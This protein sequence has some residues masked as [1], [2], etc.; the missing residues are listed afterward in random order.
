[1]TISADDIKRVKALGCLQDKTQPEY[2]NVRVITKNGRVSTDAMRTVADAADRFGSGMATLT[3]RLTFEIQGVHYDN[4][5]PLRAYLKENGLETGG[6]GTK[7]RPVVSCKGTTCQYG[8]Y[9]TY[10]LSEKAHE[11]FYE[12]YRDVKLPHKF[13]IAFGGCPN[14][15][16]KPNLNDCGVVGQRLVQYDTTKCKG[17]KVCQIEKNCPVH[18]ASVRDGK[19]FIDQEVCNH[20][21]RCYKKCPFKVSENCTYGFKLYIGGRWGKKVAMGRPLDR[22]FTSEE[23]ILDMIERVMLFF[24]AYGVSGERLSDTVS[25]MGFEKTQEILFSDELPTRKEEILAN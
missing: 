6:T 5:E 18:A 19:V 3:T 24:K 25:R 4:I 10:S 20:C 16:V 22:I 1:M 11:R 8:L 7:V 12:G 15:C 21:G 23:E 14:N 2:F 17:C 13:K 9:D